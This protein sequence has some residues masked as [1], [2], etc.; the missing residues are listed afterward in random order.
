[1]AELVFPSSLSF[2]AP[3]LCYELSSPPNQTSALAS[4]T[5]A[6][7]LLES[8]PTISLPFP[9]KSPPS[10]TPTTPSFATS[11][12][13]KEFTSHRELWRW[14]EHAL[15]RGSLLASSSTLG[16]REALKWLRTYHFYETV[17]PASFRP[18]RRAS[19]LL[20]Y[21]RALALEKPLPSPIPTSTSTALPV[22]SSSTGGL[23]SRSRGSS[24]SG[25]ASGWAK[26]V[27]GVMRRGMVILEAGGARGFP[28]AG[29]KRTE[30]EEFVVGCVGLWERGG[31]KRGAGSPAGLLLQVSLSSS[32]P[33]SFLLSRLSSRLP[34]A[35]G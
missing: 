20:L 13:L 22:A 3:G 25:S 32:P 33:L 18:E 30:V 21:V 12:I 28:K 6:I 35:E 31:E 26:E 17:Y 27:E 4:Y 1:M 29:E 2:R 8:L 10:T 9:S 15:F 24:L 34:L 11:A 14:G 16:E 7:H 23:I 5:S 19:I